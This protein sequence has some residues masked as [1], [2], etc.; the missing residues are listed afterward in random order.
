MGNMIYLHNYQD[1]KTT[2]LK[3]IP[4]NA[5]IRPLDFRD[6]ICIIEDQSQLDEIV[7]HLKQSVEAQYRS[8]I[9]P[10]RCLIESPS[11]IELLL[12]DGQT[13][14]FSKRDHY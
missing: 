14:S 6:A 4:E 3:V 13:V 5:S 1:M 11:L 12:Y 10:V 2:L 8:Y 9:H 7:N